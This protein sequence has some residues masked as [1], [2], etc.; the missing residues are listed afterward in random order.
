LTCVD[1]ASRYSELKIVRELH[2]IASLFESRVPGAIGATEELA[3][4]L[5]TVSDHLASAMLANRSQLMD[6]AFEAVK[7]MPVTRCDYFEAQGIVVATNFAYCHSCETDR[8]SAIRFF[9]SDD[10]EQVEY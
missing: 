9:N 3:A 10:V 2:V 6:R 7:Y 4:T 1:A 5:H 8:A